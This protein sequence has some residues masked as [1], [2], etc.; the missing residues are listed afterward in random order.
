M[1]THA[2]RISIRLTGQ[3]V[4]PGHLRSKEIAEIITAVEDLIAAVTVQHHKDLELDQIRIGL[5]SMAS[6]SMTLTFDP[7]LEPLTVPAAQEIGL[8]IAENQV[9]RL[10]HMAYKPLGILQAFARR[11]DGTVEFGT[12]NGSVQLLGI[13]DEQTVIPTP[14]LLTGDTE[15]Y[16]RVTRVGGATDP[17]VQFRVIGTDELIYCKASEEIACEVA[18]R[19]YKQVGLRGTA[20]WDFFTRKMESFTIEEIL[21]FEEVSAVEAFAEL[22][23]VLGPYADS[24]E[25]VDEYATHLR[26]LL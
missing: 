16:G 2:N 24:I 13:L 19:L 25:D 17:T 1:E 12:L 9:Q 6:G 26:N 15:L 11:H 23:E 14:I 7:N 4:A 20:S 5:S 21:P 10:P 18:V 22:R 8:A 3:E